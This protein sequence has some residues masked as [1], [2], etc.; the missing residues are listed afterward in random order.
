MSTVTKPIL[1]DETGQAILTQLRRI[2]SVEGR[3]A[4]TTMMPIYLGDYLCSSEYLA[5]SCLKLDDDYYTFNALGRQKAVTRGS[6]IGI[7]RKFTND[8]TTNAEVGLQ[9]K[10]RNTV[11][12]AHLGHANSCAYVPDTGMIWIAP[13]F[14]T[15]TAG[16]EAD[17]GYFYVYDLNN[18]TSAEETFTTDAG[19]VTARVLQPTKVNTFRDETSSAYTASAI[20]YDPVAEKLYY[21]TWDHLIFVRENDAWTKIGTLDLTGIDIDPRASGT[22]GFGQ[23]FAVCNGRFY[24]SS[25]FGVIATGLISGMKVQ[26]GWAMANIDSAAKYYQGEIEGFEFTSDKHLVGLTF[27]PLNAE[28]NNVFVVEFPVGE[29]APYAPLYPNGLHNYNEGSLLLSAD[30]QAR[31]SLGGAELRTLNQ[32]V[33]RFLRTNYSEIIIPENTSVVDN[34]HIY[35]SDNIQLNIKGGATY[36]A[37][38]ITIRAG[39]FSIHTDTDGATM[40]LTTSQANAIAIRRASRFAFTGNTRLTV[41]LPNRS[42]GNDFIGI[43][44]DYPNIIIRLKPNCTQGYTLKISN[45]TPLADSMY[46]MGS[47]PLNPLG[48][49]WISRSYDSNSYV[50]ST[51][52]NQ[53][54]SFWATGYHTGYLNFNIPL[55]TQLPADGTEVTIGHFGVS[56]DTETVMNVPSSKGGPPMKVRVS[57]YGYI[58]I[59]VNGTTLGTDSD[60]DWYRATIP[61]TP[62]DGWWNL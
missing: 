21:K 39:Y 43:G 30:S 45:I 46:Y 27:A 2:N 61:A 17:A 33:V 60:P 5:S 42:T 62:K 55:K 15:S 14:D 44:Y 58:I 35:M 57:P 25:E 40:I 49:K 20:S 16:T 31:F 36:Q 7:V 22:R 34:Y 6:D 32:M 1:L 56:M 24:L 53:N 26:T 23:D 11:Q 10:D 50:S 51:D 48:P 59:S 8:G 29:T 47:S 41:S 54:N 13:F 28:V 18:L 19:S 37:I 52:W 38:D 4:D 9:D 12:Y 3:I